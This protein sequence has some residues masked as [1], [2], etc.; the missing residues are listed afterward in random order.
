VPNEGTL[1]NPIAGLLV[2]SEGLELK[3]QLVLFKSWEEMG[4][5]I[6]QV[7]ISKTSVGAASDENRDHVHSKR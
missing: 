2:E 6:C 4:A 3:P 1:T 7:S 5:G